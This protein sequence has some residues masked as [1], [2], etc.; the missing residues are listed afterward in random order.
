MNRVRR[1]LTQSFLLSIAYVVAAWALLF[2]ATPLIVMAFKAEG[3]SARFLAFFCAWG[4]SAWLF[5]ACLFVANTAFNN[6]GFPILATVFNWGRA[7]LGTIPFVT[8]GAKHWG[9]EGGMMGATAG[10]AVFGI[11]AV[12]TAYW[13]TGRL[14]KRVERA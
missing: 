12:V 7:T 4:V 11:A 2:L 14:A 8:F 13:V 6:L 5:I 9:V 3:D 10:S 1:A